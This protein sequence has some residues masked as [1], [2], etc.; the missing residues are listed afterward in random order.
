MPM[1][2]I[3]FLIYLVLVLT[4]TSSISILNPND[5]GSMNFWMMVM[6]VNLL[7]SLNMYV[8][9]PILSNHKERN[10]AKI[11]GALPA[12]NVILFLYS[13]VSASLVLIDY[14]ATSESNTLFFGSYHLVIQILLLGST[15]AICLFFILSSKGAESGARDLVSR[16]ELLKALK[17]IELLHS[18][19]LQETSINLIFKDLLEHIEYK[20]P[21]PSAVNRDDFIA[22]SSQ[23]LE[24]QKIQIPDPENLRLT[25]ETILLKIKTL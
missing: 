11:I 4:W 25:I 3:V 17:N 22:L 9:A 1:S 19:E 2:K 20:M 24:L 13:F 10:S 23:I 5:L 14:F 21:H 7:I 18:D 12:I 16:H 8:S 15:A 6:W